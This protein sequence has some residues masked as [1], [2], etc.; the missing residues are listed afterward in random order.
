MAKKSAAVV[1]L[2]E[3]EGHDYPAAQSY[4]SLLF[5]PAHAAQWVADLV[6]ADMT[7]FYAKD[8][9]RASG[10]SLLGVSN[11]H[12][13]KDVRKI[14][15]GIALS[16]LPLVRDPRATRLIIADGYHRLCAVYRFD[17]DAMIPAK[18]CG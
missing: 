10:A 9:F 13:Q 12:V 1:W 8:I 14:R 6:R 11:S 3:P 5:D 17:E 16:P 4:L 2:E 15:K 18:I 7:R